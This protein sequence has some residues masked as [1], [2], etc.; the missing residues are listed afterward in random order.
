MATPALEISA[1]NDGPPSRRATDVFVAGSDFPA[2]TAVN[3]K[4]SAGGARPLRGTANVRADGSFDWSAS[5]RP[6]L[7]CNAAVGAIVHGSDG[8][9]V[10]ASTEVFCPAVP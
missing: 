5:V 3:I 2:G 8:L 4:I 7:S 9:Q 1:G 6:K 10:T